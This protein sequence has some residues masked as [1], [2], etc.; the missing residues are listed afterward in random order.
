MSNNNYA[1]NYEDERFQNVEAEKAAALS[2]TNSAYDQMINNSDKY[3]Q[4][5]Q[6]LLNQYK[7]EQVAFQ[8]EQT[9]L[10]IDQINQQKE[11]TEKDYLKEQKGAYV[12]WQKQSNPYGVNAEQMAAQGLSNTGYSESS[13]VSMFN[14]Y[15]NRVSTTR[16]VF[17]N[18]VTSFTNQIKE[19]KIAG[20]SK[21]A[22]ITYNALQ[23]SLEIGLEGFQYKNNL[24]LD[25]MNKQQEIDDRYYA[26]YQDIQNQINAENQFAEQI[27]QYE[28]NYALQVKQYN[29][30]IRQFDE[31][32][33]Y[34]KEKD[35]KEHELEI[36][37]LEEQKRQAQQE[38]ANWEK[39]FA[40][41]KQQAS[42]SSSGGSSGGSSSKKKTGSSGSTTLTQNPTNNKKVTASKGASTA[43]YNNVLQ[44]ARTT[45]NAGKFTNPSKAVQFVDD[46][47]ARSNLSDAQITKLYKSLGIK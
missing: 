31:Q 26:R 23:K 10:T 17:T 14:T 37:K 36:K 42:R 25:K 6:D 28:Q 4:D 24:V 44:M 7:D 30:D 46:I 35:A 13:Q 15:Q 2:Q 41:A 9:Q 21:I 11:Q 34:Y 32:I 43:E 3:Y 29:E 33:A 5:Q 1:I 22:E 45:Y 18:A 16:E 47:V 12:D 39:E 38:Q 8:E 27:R 19:A 20:S 40:L